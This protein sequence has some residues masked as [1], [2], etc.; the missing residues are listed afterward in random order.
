MKKHIPS[1]LFVLFA[2]IVLIR[3][4]ETV[5]AYFGPRLYTFVPINDINDVTPERQ[6]AA[7][8]ARARRDVSRSLSH[9][10]WV[11][12][13][14]CVGTVTNA[15]DTTSLEW[16]EDSYVDIKVDN[17]W[18]GDTG[19]DT[20]KAT[21]RAQYQ[22]PVTNTPVLFYFTQYERM[23]RN[24]PRSENKMLYSRRFNDMDY[25]RSVE[26]PGGLWF[27]WDK[28]SWFNIDDMGDDAFNYAS[29]LVFAVN[30][31]NTNEFY[32]VMKEGY[33][34]YPLGSLIFDSSYGALKNPDIFF[35]TNFMVN[36]MYKDKFLDEEIKRGIS[37]IMYL[38]YKIDL[39][40]DPTTII[41]K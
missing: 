1:I 10:A 21:I 15:S 11:C 3:S 35:T 26:T 39:E 18:R 7:L 14:I 33:D 5:S 4:S 8:L 34:N 37:Y 20:L 36:V 12:D 40:N 41:V 22:P 24:L 23:A 25:F 28:R 16:Y 19:S 2:L 27:V 29:N 6:I 17:Y 31:N 9:Q 38:R 13:I 30:T 32:E